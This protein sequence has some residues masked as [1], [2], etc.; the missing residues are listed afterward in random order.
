MKWL[1]LAVLALALTEDDLEPGYVPSESGFVLAEPIDDTDS[2][3]I[4]G[5]IDVPLAVRD[6]GLSYCG[7]TNLKSYGTGPFCSA[8]TDSLATCKAVSSA[9][10]WYVGGT[11]Y[12]YQCMGYYF[13]LHNLQYGTP[14]SSPNPFFVWTQYFD[15]KLNVSQMTK[16]IRS[17]TASNTYSWSQTSSISD[18]ISVSVEVS[19][20]D[21]VKVQDS[22]STTV[23]MS[24]TNTQTKQH[25]KSWSVEQDITIPP[26]T[27]VKASMVVECI[28]YT[29]PYTA[30]I[31]FTGSGMVW[32][33]S[34]VNGHYCWFMDPS[35][36]LGP[37][38]CSTTDG[39]DA[40]CKV[41]GSFAGILG[42]RSTV[43][44]GKCAL[45][46]HC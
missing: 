4:G 34:Q 12:T 43:T 7:S 46:V 33:S 21:V 9:H 20:P 1:L 38:G 6:W 37:K 41:G 36:V 44:V 10:Y 39:K 30:S 19:V 18:T 40:V 11:Q 22:F 3:L 17:E 32:C 35:K 14:Q 15:N 28:K 2:G 5:S 42:V 26:M 29:V 45:G 8:C 13:A 24:T 23:S 16:F 27:T 25:T 31:R